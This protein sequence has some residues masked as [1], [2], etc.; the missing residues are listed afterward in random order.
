VKLEDS[1]DDMKNENLNNN[2]PPNWTKVRLADICRTTSGGTPSRKYASYFK[3]N[4]PWLKSGELEYNIINSSE[5]HITKY[6]LENSSSK[7]IPKGAILMALYGATVGK[8]ALLGIDAAINQ[9]ICAIFTPKGVEN[10]FLYWYLFGYRNELLNCRK[11]G[12]QPNISQQ[13]VNNIVFPLPPLNEQKRIVAKVEELFSKLDAGI[14][15]LKKIK[16]LLKQYHQSVLKKA[17]EGELIQKW[18]QTND[19]T[20]TAKNIESPKRWRRVTLEDHVHIEARIGWKGLKKDEYQKVGPLL[21]SVR[22]IRPDGRVDFDVTDR[23]T[24]FR[25][26][27]SPGIQLKNGDILIAKDGAGIGKVGYVQNLTSRATVNSSILVVR[28][29]SVILPK[30]LFHYFR[31]PI[32]QNI[33]RKKI[34]GTAAPFIPT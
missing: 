3:G 16:I 9:A 34:A 32:F 12:A 27:E 1:L 7:I 14:E 33:V 13:I 29:S 17:F 22:E 20:V 10:K 19:S 28:P 4:I 24:E 8:L 11:G 26:N 15:Y 30:Y 31:G 2:L 5:E 21:I 18:R 25:Y 23:L 6:A